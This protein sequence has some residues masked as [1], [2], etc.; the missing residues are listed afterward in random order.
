MKKPRG[1]NIRPPPA[2]F[3]GGFLIGMLLDAMVVQIRLVGASPSTRP[4]ALAGWILFWLGM[5]ISLSGILTFRLAGTTM[6]PFVPASRLVRHGPY[7]FT[8]NPMYLGLTISYIGLALVLNT[9]WPFILLPLVLWG[10]VRFVIR[11]EE[12]Y[13]ERTF[14]SEYVE[15]KKNVRRWV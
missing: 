1:P 7:R 4:L 6:M 10:M 11:E 14:G 12:G 8:R 13:L 2:F 15:Y 9:A 5:T 3:V